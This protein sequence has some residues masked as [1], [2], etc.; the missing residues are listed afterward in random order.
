MRALQGILV[1]VAR[2]RVDKPFDPVADRVRG[3]K[4]ERR[5]KPKSGVAEAALEL[6]G[7]P[8]RRFTSG[9]ESR[10]VFFHLHGGAYVG[11]SSAV[12][13]LYT[14]IS[15]EGGPD[16]ISIDYRLAPEHPYPASLDDALTAYRSLLETMPASKIVVGGE[17][18]GGNLV[19]ALVQRLI[20]DGLPLPAAVV[21]VYPWS[22]LT[23][24][25]T[26]WTTNARQ[27]IHRK[28][29]IDQC[30]GAFAAGLPLDDPRVSPQF[31]SFTG[32]PP[33]L[34]HVGTHDCL[35]EDARVVARSMKEVGVRV[36][37]QEVLGAVHG[38][39]LLPMPESRAAMAEIR[40][41]VRAH[42]PA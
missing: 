38:F 6:G 24:T 32:F 34:I 36:T 22:D 41:F 14:G 18:A 28:G 9:G 15:A 2:W 33:A 16:V 5:F 3:A 26:T 25:S 13:R 12:G 31:G 20:E 8:G 21:P 42:L 4:M 30:A 17:S 39:T 11:G 27:D 35:L 10:G 23:Q 1:R 19:L 7:V 40:D 37:L 29:T